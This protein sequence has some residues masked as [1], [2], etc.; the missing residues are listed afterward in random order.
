MFVVVCWKNIYNLYSAGGGWWLEPT[1]GVG[2][3]PGQDLGLVGCDHCGG[4]MGLLVRGFLAR[5]VVEAGGRVGKP[6]KARKID[7][8]K[9]G[10]G[11]I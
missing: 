7:T 10:V 6:V 5:C 1:Q 4:N 11:R 8:R 3:K 9:E 2:F